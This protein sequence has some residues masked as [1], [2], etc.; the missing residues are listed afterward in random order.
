MEQNGWLCGMYTPQFVRERIKH[1]GPARLTVAPSI[2]IVGWLD[3]ERSLCDGNGCRNN[4][5]DDDDD[6]DGGA[7]SGSACRR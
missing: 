7:H 1:T 3:D 2:P 5:D 6:D 4:N